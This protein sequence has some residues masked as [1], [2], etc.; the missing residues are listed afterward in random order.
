MNL[1]NLDRSK[2]YHTAV[3]PVVKNTSVSMVDNQLYQLE[4]SFLSLLMRRVTL[5]LDYASLPLVFYHPPHQIIW[6]AMLDLSLANVVFDDVI[7][8]SHLS[9]QNLLGKAGG[10]EY[11]SRVF[12]YAP[13]N[14]DLT[15]HFNA[16]KE[17]QINH[18]FISFLK[19]SLHQASSSGFFSWQNIATQIENFLNELDILKGIN[20][21]HNGQLPKRLKNYF[22]QLEQNLKLPLYQRRLNNYVASGFSKFDK[23]LGGLLRGK[24]TILGARPGVGKTTLA[25][26]IMLNHLKN[27]QQGV[28]FA[29]FEQSF[30]HITTKILAIISQVNICNIQTLNLDDSQLAAL[31]NAASMIEDYRLHFIDGVDLDSLLTNIKRLKL[32]YPEISLVIVD[33]L[34]LIDVPYKKDKLEQ[35]NY[36]ALCF[37]NL[38]KNLNIALLVVSGLK[39][40]VLGNSLELNIGHCEYLSAHHGDCYIMLSQPNQDLSPRPDHQSLINY[41]VPKNKEGPLIKGNLLFDKLTQRIIEL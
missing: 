16:L 38:A 39:K 40:E 8:C 30:E 15:A 4:C 22:T 10:V 27:S 37:K 19:S 28:I 5:M 23:R 35:I 18:K 33:Y 32:K 14:A 6:Q 13:L 12:E 29:S 34:G 3:K 24:I 25:L 41:N 11:I 1:N 7:I 26:N 20:S 36:A 21:D 17:Y 31:K 2:L 9:K